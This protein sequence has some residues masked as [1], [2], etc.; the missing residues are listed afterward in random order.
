MT[1]ALG[2]KCP[3]CGS[4]LAMD[5]Y[6]NR[7]KFAPTVCVFCE[8]DSCDVQPITDDTSPS[9]AFADVKVWGTWTKATDTTESPS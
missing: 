3:F 7:K 8:N 5:I 2:I 4:N 9:K 1:S 6:I